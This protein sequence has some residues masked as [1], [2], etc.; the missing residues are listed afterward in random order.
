MIVIVGS[1]KFHKEI[2]ELVKFLREHKIDIEA[3]PYPEITY[4]DSLISQW[5]DKGLVYDHLHKLDRAD[6]CFI[7]NP[8][9]YVGVNSI[10]EIGY[11]INKKKPI[12]AC[13]K[14]KETCI[15]LFIEQIFDTLD[16]EQILNNFKKF[17]V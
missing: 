11:F 14:T 17:I 8:N 15:D 6:F 12:F 7:Y 9:G 3:A 10:F 16:K 13:Y 5:A 2:K 1:R 4:D